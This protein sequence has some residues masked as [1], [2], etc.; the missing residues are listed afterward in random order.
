MND[1]Q[2][3]GYK[4]IDKEIFHVHTHRCKHAA[5]APDTEYIE[6]AIE[7]GAS[8]IVFLDHAPFP[9]N[10]FGNRMDIEELEAYIRDINDLKK[11]YAEKIEILCGLEI[12]FLPSFMEYYKKLREMPGVDLMAVGQHF[13]EVEPGYYSFS[14]QGKGEVYKGL[15]HAIVQAI[16]SDLF[17]VIIHPDRAFRN[18]KRFGEK[19]KAVAKEIW[20]AVK[21][22]K[23]PIYMEKNFASMLEKRYF[24]PEFWEMEPEYPY[25]LYGADA[26]APMAVDNAWQYDFGKY[27]SINAEYPI[28]TPVYVYDWIQKLPGEICYSEYRNGNWFYR[29]RVGGC[30]VANKVRQEYISKRSIVNPPKYNY[31]DRVSFETKG[32]TVTGTIEII[33]PY[34]TFEQDEEPSYDIMVKEENCLYKHV[35]ESE[36]TFVAKANATES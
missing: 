27:Y 21:A 4:P 30:Y 16:E 8:R 24:R 18:R 11:T 20:D 19:E 23:R 5:D 2:K 13:Y 32:K 29:V 22:S 1:I 17:D 15:A 26:H 36:V 34:G 35:R 25:V 3:K 7:L 14:I 28:G 9:G 6:K 12:E 10:P 33:D 31:G